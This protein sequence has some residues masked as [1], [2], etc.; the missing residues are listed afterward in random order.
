MD[1]I[2]KLPIKVRQWLIGMWIITAQNCK[3]HIYHQGYCYNCGLMWST[4]EKAKELN[5]LEN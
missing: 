5:L 2:S 1:W 3:E 4:L